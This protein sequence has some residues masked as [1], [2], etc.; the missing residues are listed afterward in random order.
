M[1]QFVQDNEGTI[2]LV[3]ML[4]AL[5]IASVLEELLPRRK[6][7]AELK[8]RWFHNIGLTL[9]NQ[10]SASLVTAAVVIAAAWWA[11]SVGLGLLS[12]SEMGF[13]P[14]LALAILVFEFVAYWFHRAL[15]AIPWL[16]RIHAIHH[17]DTEVDFTT[18]FRNHP[19]ELYI[20]APLTVPIVLG[21]GFPVLVVTAY[22][23]IKTSISVI[24]HS[25]IQFTPKLDAM[26]RKFIIT[27]DY[28]RLH[29][30]SERKFTD[31]NFSAAFP[32]YDYLFGTARNRSFSDHDTMELGLEYFRDPA[33]SRMDRLLLMPFV[34]KKKTEKPGSA[35]PE[36]T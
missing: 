13:W 18:T 20:N 7:G 36:T 16:W 33:D 1:D 4:V 35:P 6:T 31:S 10:V 23:L 2:L 12:G 11:E 27:P 8:Q 15:H 30:C 32:L 34:W 29:H 28:H 19:L 24:A 26:L 5:V 25:N 3:G 17:S 14:M 9:I 22:Q 21:M